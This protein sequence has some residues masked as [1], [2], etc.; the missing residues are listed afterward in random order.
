MG[1]GFS[2]QKNIIPIVYAIPPLNTYNKHYIP[3]FLYNGF[4]SNNDD[5][6]NN[7]YI[8]LNTY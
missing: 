5:Q 7:K 6:P 8:E 2:N 1:L 4:K 3:T